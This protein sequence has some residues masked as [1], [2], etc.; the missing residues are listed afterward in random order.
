M[1]RR[2]ESSEPGKHSVRRIGSLVNQLISRR[3]YAQLSATEE[4]RRVICLAVDERL[5]ASIRVGNLRAGVLHVYASDSVAMQELVFQKRC[6]LARIQQ[7]LPH[8]KVTALR[9]R[10]Y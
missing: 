4:M 10:L 5:H 9:F 6:I 7:E 1:K 3:G 2:N 8:S